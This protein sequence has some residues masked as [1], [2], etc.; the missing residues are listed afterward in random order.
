MTERVLGQL[1]LNR[2]L[3]AR[4]LLLERA[5]L[6]LE[7]RRLS[8][9]VEMDASDEEHLKDLWLGVGLD[10]FLYYYGDYI[11]SGAEVD[12]W[13]SHPHNIVLDFLSRLGI[14]GFACG[15]WLI[16]GFWRTAIGAY[17]KLAADRDGRALCVGLMALVADMLAHGLVDHSFFLLDLA[18]AFLL[19]LALVQYL[20]STAGEA[21]SLAKG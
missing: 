3:L 21:A 8:F 19:A 20:R 17:R 15:V 16:A 11:R 10:N 1:A 5:S 6:D 7:W 9:Q 14:L 13:L 12:R 2:A 18:Y 4:Q